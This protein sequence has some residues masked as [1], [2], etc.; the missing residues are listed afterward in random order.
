MSVKNMFG[1]EQPIF[2]IPRKLWHLKH[3]GQVIE[4]FLTQ[5]ECYEKLHQVQGQSWDYA[6]KWGGYT[7]TREV[8]KL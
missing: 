5:N 2:N 3:D 6:L 4:K 8:E 1:S 7:I